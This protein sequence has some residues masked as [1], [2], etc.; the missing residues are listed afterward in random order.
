MLRLVPEHAYSKSEGTICK[1]SYTHRHLRTVYMDI[2]THGHMDNN[3][4]CFLIR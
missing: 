2:R 4:Q 1:V 3:F